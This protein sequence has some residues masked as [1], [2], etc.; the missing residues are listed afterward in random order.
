MNVVFDAIPLNETEPRDP[1]H[2]L[3]HVET[4]A[5]CK[6]TGARSIIEEQAAPPQD[7]FVPNDIDFSNPVAVKAALTQ[8][9][10]G[11]IVPDDTIE[12]MCR[13]G[14]ARELFANCGMDENHPQ[15]VALREWVAPTPD[16]L[17]LIDDL[18]LRAFEIIVNRV[19]GTDPQ[20]R[21]LILSVADSGVFGT[22]AQANLCEARTIAHV[23][24]YWYTPRSRKRSPNVMP[25]LFTSAEEAK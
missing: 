25:S 5:L 8:T 22:L 10:F 9:T 1:A 4:A 20:R 7:A 3:M 2:G 21:E 14:I 18:E 24:P 6:E 13:A 15:L 11:H 16:H 17:W 23:R 12:A 19:H